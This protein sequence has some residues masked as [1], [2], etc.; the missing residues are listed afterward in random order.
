MHFAIEGVDGSGKSTLVKLLQEEFKDALFIR[1]PGTSKFAEDIRK[2]VFNN[3]ENIEPIAIQI[4]MLS[5]RADLAQYLKDK[6][7]IIADRCFISGCYCEK[8]KKKSDIEDWIKLNLKYVRTPDLIIYLDITAE[9]S[10]KR[11]SNRNNMEAFDTNKTEEIEKRIKAYKKWLDISKHFYVRYVMV[12]ANKSIEEVKNEVSNII[13]NF[14][15][16]Q[17]CRKKD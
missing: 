10:V 3:F 13:R 5:A 2:A 17:Q 9:E 14:M 6:P 8:L 4:A 11:L 7:F 15:E 16:T 12:N 1:E